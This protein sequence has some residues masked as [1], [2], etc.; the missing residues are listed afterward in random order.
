MRVLSEYSWGPSPSPPQPPTASTLQASAQG[1]EQLHF[2]A[3]VPCHPWAGA[4]GHHH[5]A[6]SGGT[7]PGGLAFSEMAEPLVLEPFMNWV[8]ILCPCC[9]RQ[10]VGEV[11]NP[12]RVPR[13]G[14]N[15]DGAERPEVVGRK[16]LGWVTAAVSDFSCFTHDMG[17][18]WSC[19]EES[20]R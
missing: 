6:V 12:D 11:S 2:F 9:A 15:L 17:G 18:I 14:E 19:F 20:L 16:G 1:T 7:V 8:S 10:W 4:E 5:S 13:L 3:G